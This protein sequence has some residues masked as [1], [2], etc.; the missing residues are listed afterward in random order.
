MYILLC[1]KFYITSKWQNKLVDKL[2]LL[3]SFFME[4]D[5]VKADTTTRAGLEH[6]DTRTTPQVN[7]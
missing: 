1:I 5:T 7:P 4:I 2:F 3:L 6:T